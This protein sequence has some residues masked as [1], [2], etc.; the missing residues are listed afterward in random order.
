M[1]IK[2]NVKRGFII[3]GIYLIIG[4]CVL[5]MAER[6]ERLENSGFETKSSGVSIKI[7]N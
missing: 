1:Q 2:R 6:I 3:I 4:I 5:M 7:G